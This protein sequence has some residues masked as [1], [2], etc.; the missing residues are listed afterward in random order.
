MHSHSSFPRGF[1]KGTARGNP[2]CWERLALCSGTNAAQSS[3]LKQH[4]PT[5]GCV[6]RCAVVLPPLAIR[7]VRSTDMN[8][9]EPM[10]DRTDKTDKSAANRDPLTGAPGSHPV[11]AGVG[12]AVGTAVGA[13]TATG[14]AH[15]SRGTAPNR[16]RAMRGIA[17][18]VLF[19]ATQ[20]ETAA[21]SFAMNQG[22][23]RSATGAPS[24]FEVQTVV[25]EGRPRRPE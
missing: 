12:A 18:S 16:R 15:R 10:T 1:Y 24:P 14:P 2:A 7:R 5:N 13:G 25:A 4:A 9:E 23:E 11:G 22:S 8:E 17:W 6:R 3:Q 19:R 20:T 21:R